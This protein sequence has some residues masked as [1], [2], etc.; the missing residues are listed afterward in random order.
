L[1]CR[2]FI[3]TNVRV[4]KGRDVVKKPIHNLEDKNG[5]KLGEKQV[6]VVF[7][8]SQEGGIIGVNFFRNDILLNRT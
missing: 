5:G 4:P 6:C 2:D 3:A 1:H 8:L 7:N